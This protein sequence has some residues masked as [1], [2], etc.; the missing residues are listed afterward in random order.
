MFRTFI[1]AFGI[2]YDKGAITVF[3]NWGGITWYNIKP[4]N[5]GGCAKNGLS[6]NM[7]QQYEDEYNENSLIYN[8][9]SKKLKEISGYLRDFSRNLFGLL[10]I[11]LLPF[12][13]IGKNK[14]I[15]FTLLTKLLCTIFIISI[16]SGIVNTKYENY[17]LVYMI[18]IVLI[19]SNNAIDLF[20][21]TIHKKD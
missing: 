8:Q 5:I 17:L 2:F 15:G 14:T 4:I 16:F 9:N 20:K 3:E 13:V 12:I 10:M 19:A 1:S 11:V 18:F 21:R 7:Y 6:E